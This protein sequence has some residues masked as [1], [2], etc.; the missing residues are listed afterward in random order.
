MQFPKTTNIQIETPSDTNPNK[1]DALSEN[2]PNLAPETVEQALITLK[3]EYDRLLA[4]K[5]QQIKER[6][7][8][9]AHLQATVERLSH[10]P[11]VVELAGEAKAHLQWLDEQVSKVMLTNTNSTH[12]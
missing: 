5:D 9:I 11:S 12:H 3:E 1:Q 2:S 10:R 6:D 4:L 8:Q 7:K